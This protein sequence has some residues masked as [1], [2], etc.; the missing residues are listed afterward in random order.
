MEFHYLSTAS[1]TPQG[2]T[3][4]HTIK[5]SQFR[6]KCDEN[7][8]V[9]ILLNILFSKYAPTLNPLRESTSTAAALGRCGAVHGGGKAKLSVLPSP[10]WGKQRSHLAV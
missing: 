4:H 7:C 8:R 10:D 3:H 6:Q 2:Y 9:K 1:M 5:N